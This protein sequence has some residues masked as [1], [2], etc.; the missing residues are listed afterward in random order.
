M[1]V[2]KEKS[3]FEND[4]RFILKPCMHPVHNPPGHIVIPAGKILRHVCPS[5]GQVTRISSQ[6]PIMC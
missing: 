6:S 5:C 1:N 2:E 3:G 4:P